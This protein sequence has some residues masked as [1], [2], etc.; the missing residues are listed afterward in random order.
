PV[1]VD[2][3]GVEATYRKGV[4]TVQ[5]PKSSAAREQ[6]RKITVKTE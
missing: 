6:T 5:V 2:P 1:E 4:L 3:D